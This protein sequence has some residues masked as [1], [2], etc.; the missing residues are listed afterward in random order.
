M[1]EPMSTIILSAIVTY[2][3]SVLFTEQNLRT[4]IANLLF[5][6]QIMIDLGKIAWWWWSTVYTVNI[7]RSS[8]N[9]PIE[10]NTN[11]VK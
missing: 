1:N 5:Q 10:R 6:R 2:G 3:P 8:T 4:T 9:M 7:E 11:P